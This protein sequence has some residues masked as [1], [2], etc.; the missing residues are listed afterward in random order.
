[1]PDIPT[2]GQLA[3]L[4][5]T[6]VFFAAAAAF[7]FAR[8]RS[9]D[10]RLR[11]AAKSCLY[12]GILLGIGVL[13]WHS[14]RRGSW[15]PLEDNFEALTWLGLLLALFL[16]YLQRAHPLRGLDGFLLPVVIVLLIAAAYFGRQ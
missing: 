2:A 12:W 8:R 1:M 7:S 16:A 10:N 5:A 4:A 3:L 11:I 13:V 14:L 6:V 15:L 9:E